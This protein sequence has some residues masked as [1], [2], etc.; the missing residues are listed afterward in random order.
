MEKQELTSAMDP[1]SNELPV[2]LK[3]SVELA[4]EKGASSWL[5]TLRIQE[6]GFCLHKGAFRDALCLRYGWKPS[7]LPSR[8][9][10]DKSFS[11]EHVLSCSYGGFSSIR[12]SEIRDITAH[13][14]SKVCHNVGI[15]PELQPLTGERFHFRSANVEDGA[16]MDVRAENFWDPD[17]QSAFLM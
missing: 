9:V 8:C 3:H 5:S 17:R 2:S 10:C 4:S 12:H 11:V 1:V 6:H 13:L 7:F 15:E 16:R 14:M